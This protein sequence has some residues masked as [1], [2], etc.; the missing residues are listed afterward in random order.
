M[1]PLLYFKYEDQGSIEKLIPCA[2]KCACI[3]SWVWGQ[4]RSERH[5]CM[6]KWGGLIVY[7]PST[8]CGVAENRL[9]GFFCLFTHLWSNV[10]CQDLEALS[11]ASQ[12]HIL[13]G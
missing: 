7:E 2:L 10:A 9:V 1:G 11:K 8:I 13:L 6:G 12:R 5:I 3:S 4:E